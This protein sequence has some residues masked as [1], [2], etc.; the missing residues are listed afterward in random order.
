MLRLS[1]LVSVL[2]LLVTPVRAQE[3]VHGIAMHGAPKYEAGFAHLDYASPAAP[4]G[5][6]LRMAATGSFDN[7][8]AASFKGNKAAG[9]HLT[10]ATLMARIWDEPFS[11]YDYVAQS[12]RLPE[13]RSWIEFKLNPAARF[14]TG[15]AITVSDVIFTFEALRDHG[16]PNTRRIYGLVD[17]VEQTGQDTIRFDLGD[18][19]DRETALILAM[20]PVMSRSYWKTRDISATTLETPPTAGPYRIVMMEAGRTITY[21][22]VKSWWGASLP[23]MVGHHNFDRVIYDYYRDGDVALAGFRAGESDLRRE[24]SAAKWATG[25]DFSDAKTGAVKLEMLPHGRPE[26]ARALI[27]NTRKPVFANLDV[28]KAL[29]LTFDFEWMNKTLF[30]GAFKRMAS[31]FPNSGLAHRGRP[32]GEELRILRAY[33]DVLPSELFEGP[34]RPPM[35]D[36]SGPTGLRANLRE[37][38]RLL[39]TAGY[40]SGNG[41]M[42]NIATG[43]PLTFE[44]LLSNPSDEK[45]ALTW[46]ESLRRIGIEVTVRT[47]DSTQYIGRREAFD[48]D[49]ILDKWISTLSPGNEQLFY[50]GSDAADQN[51]S[52]NYAGVKSA[53][54]DAIAAQIAESKTR[55]GLVA[56]TRALDR[57]LCFGHYAIP[58]YYLGADRVAYRNTLAR[59]SVTPLYGMVIETWWS[60]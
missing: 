49:M 47:V 5:G 39:K 9:L 26:W 10:A 4:K 2:L 7:L 15:S 16:R 37:A 40:K 42:M 21:E 30:H 51:G 11:L 28:R 25:Y 36:G 46:A 23:V 52:R 41:N 19:Y 27:F 45:L 58:L 3:W 20:M 17:K 8:N 18:G 44:V 13:D 6:D 31:F 33:R 55:D 35:T 59:P 12:V 56:A 53:A 57:A 43:E 1:I 24:W 50:W 29:T 22:R 34:Y 14:D 54:I 38:V 48:Y 60:R 32:A